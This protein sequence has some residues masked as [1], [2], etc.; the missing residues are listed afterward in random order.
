MSRPISL[1]TIPGVGGACGLIT[2]SSFECFSGLV[3][4]LGSVEMD[5]DGCVGRL[6]VHRSRRNMPERHLEVSFCEVVMVWLERE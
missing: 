1:A 6:P 2:S 3:M 4:L 5:S